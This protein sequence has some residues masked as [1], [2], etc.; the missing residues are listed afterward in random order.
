MITGSERNL[1]KNNDIK[2]LAVKLL[3]RRNL[4]KKELFEKLKLKFDKESA[5]KISDEMELSGI[6]NDERSAELFLYNLSEKK[7]YSNSKIMNELLHKGINNELIDEIFKNCNLSEEERAMKFLKKKYKQGK[8]NKEKALRSLLRLGYS[9]EFIRNIIS[10]VKS[11]NERCTSY[12]I[13][14]LC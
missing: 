14:E 5:L 11:E 7:F 4:T 12:E 9:F 6:V 8:I 3:A 10:N 1:M 13:D 2:N